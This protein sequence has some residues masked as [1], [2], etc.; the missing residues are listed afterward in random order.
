MAINLEVLLFTF[1][2]ISFTNA[3]FFLVFFLQV[4]IYLCWFLTFLFNFHSA[5]ILRKWNYVLSTK[6]KSIVFSWLWAEIVSVLGMSSGVNIIVIVVKIRL[7]VWVCVTILLFL[8]FI[9][10]WGVLAKWFWLEVNC[11]WYS[12]SL[13]KVVI[14]S[15]INCS[16]S[17]NDIKGFIEFFVLELLLS[18][19]L[20]KECG[21]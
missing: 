8:L 3:I 20:S 10:K 7:V 5:G 2:I 16:L 17:E 19:L 1:F 9:R 4:T 15:S 12:V 18:V 21:L 13:L 11:G 14:S 6:E